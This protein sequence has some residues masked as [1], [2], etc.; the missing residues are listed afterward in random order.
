M[1]IKAQQE[2]T[3][4]LDNHISSLRLICNFTPLAPNPSILDLYFV[5]GFRSTHFP[6]FKRLSHHYPVLKMPRADV[7][8]LDKRERT[9]KVTA[10]GSLVRCA[11]P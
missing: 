8:D 3:Q 4:S 6:L 10:T 2:W 7:R 11:V 5:P 1:Q 9:D